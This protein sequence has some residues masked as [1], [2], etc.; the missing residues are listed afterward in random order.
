MGPKTIRIT[1][2]L[3]VFS[4]LS[5]FIVQFV[6]TKKNIAIQERKIAIQERKDS[7]N[8][9]HFSEQVHIALK[10]TLDQIA[11][12]KSDSSDMYGAVKQ[13]DINYYTVDI[14]EELHPFYLET[15]LKR[16][17][18]NQH[19]HQDFQY[20]IYDCFTDSIVFGNLIKF[21]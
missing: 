2:I 7:L 9:I 6:W 1:I 8:L 14:N 19:I 20:G 17:F 3:G 13:L 4:L 15:L 16:E 18:Y 11:V 10:N 12:D 5:I 21:F